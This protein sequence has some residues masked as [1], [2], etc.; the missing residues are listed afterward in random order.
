MSN[1]NTAETRIRQ[2]KQISNAIQ[3]LAGHTAWAHFWGLPAPNNPTLGMYDDDFYEFQFD[4]RYELAKAI[5][6]PKVAPLTLTKHD[7]ELFETAV[8]IVLEVL[9]LTFVFPDIR[10]VREVRARMAVQLAAEIN[11]KQDPAF[12]RIALN[13]LGEIARDE[14]F[15]RAVH[16]AVKEI[17]I[18]THY[19]PSHH[20]TDIPLEDSSMLT[21]RFREALA[22]PAD[23][24]C[25]W[26]TIS[27]EESL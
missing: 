17:D 2:L 10:A 21:I 27:R 3:K 18:S 24:S 9:S 15:K 25:L 6:V 7:I 19:D 16:E 20:F 8:S 22:A 23:A 26:H 5:D 4:L 12:T 1:K 14:P 11:Q 13:F